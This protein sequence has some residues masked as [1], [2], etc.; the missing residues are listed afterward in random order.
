MARGRVLV[1][2]DEKELVALVRYHL[3]REGFQ[4]EAASGGEAGLRRA[5]ED[6]PAAVILDR[7]LPT[8][9]G[10]E[11]CRRIRQEPRTAGVPVVLL[12][13]R[14]AEFERVAGFEA[15]ADDYLC[16]P[17]S[18]RELVA[19]VKAVLRRVSERPAPLETVR[20]GPLEIDAGRHRV[21]FCGRSVALTAGE[22]R[23]LRYL[24]VRCGRVV[25]RSEI[26]EGALDGHVD[27]LSRTVDVHL[28]SVRRKLGRGAGFIQTVRGVGYRLAEPAGNSPL[29]RAE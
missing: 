25:G 2:D 22:F 7:S 21:L 24:A 18:P 4:V 11:V 27:G 20:V 28:A 6:P 1:V 19:R 23:I 8:L 14:T 26:I 12:T 3:E 5:L 9:D 10:L 17:F 15:G 16:K 13:A 29:A